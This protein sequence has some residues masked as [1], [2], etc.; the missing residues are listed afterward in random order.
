MRNTAS[1]LLGAGPPPSGTIRW[2]R[3]VRW[4]LPL[5]L[6]SV[7]LSFELNEHVLREPMEI[8]PGLIGEIII[9]ATIGPVAVALTLGWMTRLIAGYQRTSA[10]LFALNQDLERSV[11]DRTEN[12]QAASRQLVV[13]NE[14]LSRANEELR[15]LDRLKSEFVSLVSHQLR[16]PLTNINGALEVIA[17]DAASLPAASRRT[18][19]IL[20][21]EGQRLSHLIQAIL[22]I[23]RLESGRLTPRLGAVA[24]EPLL[25]RT[26]Q[27]V[28]A[29][30]PERSWSVAVSPALPP[31]WA[32]EVLAEEVVRNLLE[33][34]LRYSPADRPIEVRAQVVGAHIEVSVTDHGPGV[35]ATEREKIF[36]S[37]HRVDADDSTV[38]G[39]GLGLY[40]ADKLTRAQGGSIRVETPIHA[41][42]AAPGSR[43]T[44]S[45][46][47]A[48]DAPDETR[49]RS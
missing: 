40:F 6:A 24:V 31:A 28:L 23:S 12:L 33:N 2:L 37:F 3:V 42:P 11:E 17:A 7:A 34:A 27:S 49:E 21:I 1:Q 29:A 30:S 48:G 20:G 45:L 44:F 35:P 13:A 26:S 39:Y 43:F 10:E 9:F 18:L 36:R 32:D 14:S 25:V 38:A 15:Q 47:I 5:L 16:A 4:L 19:E 22:E 8:S 46:P 41:E